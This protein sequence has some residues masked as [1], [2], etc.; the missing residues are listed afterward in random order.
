MRCIH[1]V[2]RLEL[3]FRDFEI[4][5]LDANLRRDG[6]ISQLPYPLWTCHSLTICTHRLGYES[7]QEE[8]E[9]KEE[10]V[11]QYELPK[12]NHFNEVIN[13]GGVVDGHFNSSACTQYYLDKV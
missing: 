7:Q 8:E 12:K 10:I 11:E 13:A 4:I 5:K 9:K 3:D 1:K 2:T 6:I